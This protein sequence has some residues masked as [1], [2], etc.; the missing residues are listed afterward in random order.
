V[1]EIHVLVVLV[2]VAVG[3]EGVRVDMFEGRT[4]LYFA[5]RIPGA[6]REAE[7]RRLVRRM[8]L[9]SFRYL[10]LLGSTAEIADVA[11]AVVEGRFELEAAVPS[12]YLMSAVILEGI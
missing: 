10:G 6:E 7:E 1:A 5:D 3:K 2:P 11:V 8:G 12:C 4:G 9:V